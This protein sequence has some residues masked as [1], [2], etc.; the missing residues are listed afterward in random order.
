MSSLNERRRKL[1]GAAQ[2][3]TPECRVYHGRSER[4]EITARKAPCPL[5]AFSRRGVRG[6][7]P[8][9]GAAGRSGSFIPRE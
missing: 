8:C 3:L 5:P 6:G 4:E 1:G 7:S 9:D 2:S